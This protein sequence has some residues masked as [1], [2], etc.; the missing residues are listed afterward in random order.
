[1]MDSKAPR[2]FEVR[3]LRPEEIRTLYAERLTRDFSPDELTPLP[4]IEQMLAG[5]RYACYGAVDGDAILAY[6]FFVRLDRWALVDY[7]AVEEGLR[8]TGI[9]SRFLRALADGPLRGTAC[10]LLEVEAPER[11]QDEAERDTRNRRLAFYLRNGLRDTGVGAVAWHVPYRILELPL[12]APTPAEQVRAIY[13]AI[14]RSMVSEKI[15][16]NMVELHT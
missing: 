4:I 10:A 6:A 5:G 9:G 1:M 12:G 14:Y 13:A 7:Y 2:A 15:F 3:E 8:D 16:D 11:A